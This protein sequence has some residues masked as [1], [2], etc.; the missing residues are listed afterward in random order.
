MSS[1]HLK[2]VAHITTHCVCSNIIVFDYNIMW[3]WINATGCFQIFT[4]LI[5]SIFSKRKCLNHSGSAFETKACSV[6]I[7]SGCVCWRQENLLWQGILKSS[8]LPWWVTVQSLELPWSMSCLY[9]LIFWL[10]L[11]NSFLLFNHQISSKNILFS[12]FLHFLLLS[13]QEVPKKI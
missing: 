5:Y 6:E 10:K 9:L 1:V 7:S 4:S 8:A 11:M 3:C 2:T 13:L 12:R